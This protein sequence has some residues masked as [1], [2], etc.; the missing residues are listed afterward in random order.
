[1]CGIDEPAVYAEGEGS[2]RVVAESSGLVWASGP[3]L[4]GYRPLPRQL[5]L[6]ARSFVGRDKHRSCRESLPGPSLDI[7]Q[8]SFFFNRNRPMILRQLFLGLSLPVLFAPP[9]LSQGQ[10]AL[11]PDLR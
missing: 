2:P 10:D 6:H 4:Q 1:V 8:I 9:G 7:Q 11:R 3:V 5:N